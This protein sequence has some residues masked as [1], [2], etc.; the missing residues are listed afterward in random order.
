MST[1]TQ[2]T[3][4]LEYKRQI[5]GKEKFDLDFSRFLSGIKLGEMF[6]GANDERKKELT[7]L[8]LDEMTAVFSAGGK[9]ETIALAAEWLLDSYTGRDDRLN[10]IQSIVVLEVLLG[11]KAASDEVGLGQLLRN[12]CA[13]M[14]GRNRDDRDSLMKEFYE[15]YKI[16][17]QIVHRGKARLNFKEQVLFM[18]LERFAAE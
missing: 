5:D 14:L 13:Y 18:S 12:R 6:D 10:Y 11:D 4:A 15:I 8:I 7:K 3:L 2:E 9:A 17:S 1:I 16:R